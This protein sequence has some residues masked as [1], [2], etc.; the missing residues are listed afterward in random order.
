MVKIFIGPMS[1]NIVDTI[2]EFCIENKISIGLIPSRR[3]VEC[4]GGYV[5]NW[6]TKNFVNYVRTKTNNII[7]VRDHGGPEQGLN[8]DDGYVSISVDSL[9]FDVIH[10]DIWKKYKDI[11]NAV[12]QTSNYINHCLSINSNLFFEVGTEQ[13]IRKYS[14]KELDIFLYKLKNKLNNNFNSIKYCVV[15]TGTALKEIYNIGKYNEEKLKE[16]IKVVK[17]Y[18]LISKEH[19]GDYL[20]NKL[21]S[22]KFKLGLDCINIAPEFGNIETKIIYNNMNDVEKER[23]F[24]I[25]LDSKKWC[26]WVENDF[27]PYQNKEQIVNISGH[28]VFTNS[29]IKQFVNEDIKENIKENIK[30]RLKELINL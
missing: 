14:P 12:E 1:L 10:I 13:S 21:I 16:M 17:K 22:E 30:K 18:N 29:F 27:D 20:S 4:S 2:I 3:Q 6:N 11:D 26:K 9:L 23:F 28:Y 25:C 8:S 24:Q 19:N 5:N 15:Q 7:L